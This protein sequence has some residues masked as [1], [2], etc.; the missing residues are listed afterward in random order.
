MSTSAAHLRALALLL[1]RRQ[2]QLH[3]ICILVLA[4]QL[5]AQPVDLFLN[6]RVAGGGG[7]QLGRS[8]G[9]AGSQSPE[10]PQQGWVGALCSG[11]AADPEGVASPLHHCCS[12]GAL[13]H[14]AQ[15]LNLLGLALEHSSIGQHLQGT[16]CTAEL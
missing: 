8:A 16:G 3:A 15:L 14:A 5:G 2:R 6:V 12:P 9:R 7:D 13:Q 10:Q 4:Q 1:L 11:S